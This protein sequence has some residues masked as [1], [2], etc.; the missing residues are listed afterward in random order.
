[1]KRLKLQAFALG[2]ESILSR[3]QMK[4]VLGGDVDDSGTGQCGTKENCS[5]GACPD[6]KGGTCGLSNHGQKCTCATVSV[7]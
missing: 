4:N 1:M 7:G 2:V 3:S 5:T 6:G